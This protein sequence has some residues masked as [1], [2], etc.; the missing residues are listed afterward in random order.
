ME[1]YAKLLPSLE[2][3]EKQV[4]LATKIRTI[5]IKDAF[6]WAVTVKK[7]YKRLQRH[8][9]EYESIFNEK[10]AI[11]KESFTDLKTQKSASWWINNR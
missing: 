4:E 10:L 9:S 7:S 8:G 5:K 6:E 2:G 3:S 1:D 11:L